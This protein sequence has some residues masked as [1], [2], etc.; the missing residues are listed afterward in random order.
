MKLFTQQS[1]YVA[2]FLA[3][4]LAT[5]AGASAGERQGGPRGPN[6]EH[7]AAELG[8]SEAQTVEIEQIL[9]DA[10][11]RHEALRSSARGSTSG[12]PSPELRAEAMALRDETQARIA[13][14][15]TPDQLA[16]WEA[17][18]AERQARRS[19]HQRSGHQ[20]S[21]HQRQGGEL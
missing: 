8:L 18:R 5:T 11:E 2:V 1:F 7:L 10:R 21:G 19:G 20:R 14:V 13:E 9:D 3:A 6:A 4:A 12:R 16:D 15:L 17:L